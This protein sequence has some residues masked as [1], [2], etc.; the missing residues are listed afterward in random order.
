MQKFHDFHFLVKMY[1]RI[2]CLSYIFNN[3]KITTA[4]KMS[5]IRANVVTWEAPIQSMVNQYIIKHY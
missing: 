4:C 1:M 5:K 2:L 3:T